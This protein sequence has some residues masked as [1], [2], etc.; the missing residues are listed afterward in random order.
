MEPPPLDP[1]HPTPAL[2]NARNTRHTIETERRR[3]ATPIRSTPA[4]S[5]PPLAAIQLNP[6]SR[7]R[8]AEAAVGAMVLTVNVV[9][10][11][12]VELLNG[13]DAGLSE[14]LISAVS[15]LGA[16]ERLTVPVKPALAAMIFS[17]AVAEAPGLSV[18]LVGLGAETE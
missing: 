2:R 6:P 9:C 16:Q 3:G 4:N 18:K 17:V 7:R 15:E 11:L 13:I 12:V 8:A 14:Q 1:P 5:A 10:P